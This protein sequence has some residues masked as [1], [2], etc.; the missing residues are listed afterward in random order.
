[1]LYS[2][3]IVWYCKGSRLAPLSDYAHNPIYQ[4]LPTM[5][6]Y[7]ASAESL[8]IKDL[9]KGYTN[10]IEK[11]TRDDSNL[12]VTITLKN[13]AAKKKEISCNL[14][15]YLFIYGYYQGEIFLLAIKRRAYYELQGIRSKQTKKCSKLR[16]MGKVKRP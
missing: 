8:L 11:W 4:E 3:I 2:Q 12:S 14:F 5:S 10:E 7:F 6:K 13:D 15:I 16:T 9:E 1:M